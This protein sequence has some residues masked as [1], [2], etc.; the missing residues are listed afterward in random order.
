MAQNE[1]RGKTRGIAI[2]TIKGKN[3]GRSAQL[4]KG[5]KGGTQL[6]DREGE[7]QGEK[8][9]ILI[10]RGTFLNHLVPLKG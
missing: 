6:Y 5:K 1:K 10:L 8:S 3:A 2:L 4:E 9:G 7:E